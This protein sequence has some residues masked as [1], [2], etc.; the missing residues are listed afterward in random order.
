MNKQSISGHLK[1]NNK[2]TAHAALWA[3]YR[4]GKDAAAHEE[5]AQTDPDNYDAVMEWISSEMDT[6]VEACQSP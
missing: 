1:K 2:L 5:E 6:L 3:A 4:L